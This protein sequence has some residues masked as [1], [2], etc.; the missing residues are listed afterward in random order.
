V[1][2]PGDIIQQIAQIK[3]GYVWFD[4]AGVQ[5]GNVHQS[6]QQTFHVI[7]GGAD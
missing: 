5:L 7:Q 4:N 3:R 1:V 2:P 6:T